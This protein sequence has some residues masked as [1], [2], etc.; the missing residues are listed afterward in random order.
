[1]TSFFLRT[2]LK[3]LIRRPR[4]LT[5]TDRNRYRVRPRVESL[6]DRTLLTTVLGTGG[7][8]TLVVSWNGSA[9]VSSLNGGAAQPINTAQPF[10]FSATNDTQATFEIMNQT[11]SEFAPTGG[12]FF[13]A[14]PGANNSLED[15]GGTAAGNITETAFTTPGAGTISDGTQNISFTGVDPI[16][17]SMAGSLTVSASNSNSTINY[18][19]GVSASTGML[20]SG[21]G[22]VSGA[23][24]PTTEFTAQT[25][26]AINDPA[27]NNTVN[28]NNP[29]TPTSLTGITVNGTGSGADTLIANG[30]T[31]ADSITYSPTG[32]DTG[33]ITGAGP[34]PITFN[35][36]E[37]VQINGQGGNDTLTYNTPANAN[38]GSTVVYAPGANP[39]AG[40]VTGSQNGGPALAP[41]TFSGLGGTGS[42]TFTTANAARSDHLIVQDLPG[43][44]SDVF[45]VN[46][47]GAGGV[48]GGSV[49]TVAIVHAAP[50]NSPVTLT[51]STPGVSILELQGLGGGDTFNVNGALPYTGL[52]LNDGATVN[53]AAAVGPVT[54][55]IG[56][57][58]PGSPNPNTVITGYGAPVTLIG[59]DTAN[60][61]ANSNN[62]TAV[63]TS[64]NDNWIFTPTG[65]K[66]ATFY[67]SIGSGNNLVPNTVFNATNV[68]GVFQALGGTGGNADELTVQGSDAR[69]LFEINKTS[70]VVQVLA[71]NVTGLLEVQAQ[72]N[73]PIL[74]VLGEG[75]Q[76]TFQVIPGTGLPAGSIDNLLINI[77]GGTTGAN[78][79]LVVASSFGAT[80]GTLAAN[81]FVVVNK[82]PTV[83]SGT[84]RVFTAAVADPDINYQ[85]IQVVSANVAGTSLNPNLLVM[86]PDLNEPNNQQGNA[87][88]LGSGSTIQVQNATI[89]PNSTEFPGVPADNDFYQVVAQTT[90]TLD[91]QISYRTFS[92]AL[93]PGG[94]NLGLQVLDANGNVL[95]TGSTA[96]TIPAVAGQS[97]FLDVFG[98]NADGTPNAA[99][100]NGY[101]LTVVNPPP[102]PASSPVALPPAPVLVIPNASVS[103][104]TVLSFPLAPA[105]GNPVLIFPT[106]VTSK[107]HKFFLVFVINNSNATISGRL[108]LFGLT[109]KQFR[110]GLTAFGAP[111]LDVFLPP[112]GVVPLLLPVK[113]FF[114]LFVAG[115]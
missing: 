7:N 45:N 114:P 79:A 67:D 101:D 36:V 32:P 69:D 37:Q 17:I 22:Q 105:L 98:A 65:A 59:V 48:G 13:N 19:E 23:G 97:Y 112:G 66:A 70:G 8:D 54:V 87:T 18:T 90:G 52:L 26:L 94:G 113:S 62:M 99:V 108:V 91:F 85:N 89:F 92:P 78:N 103:A 6:E 111:A 49:G 39:D 83:N 25:A 5:Q 11:G 75:G 27:G 77:D 106:L 12:I 41:L 43:G 110:T 82:S 3:N 40:S 1:M 34:V 84:V 30:T 47:G 86:G 61:N 20:D 31:G 76:N 24:I 107:G 72:G 15:L 57:N 74:N 50:D 38:A 63:G 93:L 109:A 44:A 60:L 55:N 104:N 9:Y 51:L 68:T 53:L 81:Q 115:F 29:H 14:M 58:T 2:W 35:T 102:A 56:D 88:F 64:Q 21:W 28:L 95:G 96:I 10:T 4:P 42:L 100:V 71:N 46:P 80:P 33:G 16:F 73:V